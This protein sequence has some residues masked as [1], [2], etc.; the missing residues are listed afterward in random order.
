MTNQSVLVGI[1]PKLGETDT[2]RMSTKV[3]F[4][5]V[6]TIHRDRPGLFHSTFLLLAVLHHEMRTTSTTTACANDFDRGM[7]HRTLR[8]WSRILRRARSK[9]RFTP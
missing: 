3:R 2:Y 4:L 8:E 1:W 5:G 7:V 9:H 6:N